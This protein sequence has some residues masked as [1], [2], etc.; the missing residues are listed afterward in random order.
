MQQN[1]AEKCF[2]E[3]T[4]QFCFAERCF[5]ENAFYIRNAI[6]PFKEDVRQFARR[7]NSRTKTPI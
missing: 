2:P 4:F 1:K 6:R 7:Q 3:N 5:P